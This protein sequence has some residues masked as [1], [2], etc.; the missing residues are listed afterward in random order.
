MEDFW[1]ELQEVA[2]F[3]FVER[4]CWGENVERENDRERN[5]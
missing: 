3:F 1:C 5:C 2:D 4:K